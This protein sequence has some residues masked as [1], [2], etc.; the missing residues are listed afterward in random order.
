MEM[1]ILP[2][3][4][5]N[6]VLLL[7]SYITL[8]MKC[9]PAEYIVLSQ[10]KPYILKPAIV[11]IDR[12]AVYHIKTG[13][14]KLSASSHKANLIFHHVSRPWWSL[15]VSLCF[16]EANPLFGNLAIAHFSTL[17]GTPWVIGPET[18]GQQR[19]GGERVLRE[20]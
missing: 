15:N 20:I 8:K 6:N 14:K 13:P 12:V 7:L 3:P 19:I 2:S 11:T 4:L 1:L 5:I 17:K 16:S 10:C 9:I 18:S